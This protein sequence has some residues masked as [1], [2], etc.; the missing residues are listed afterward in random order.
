MLQSSQNY[1]TASL[2]PRVYLSERLLVDRPRHAVSA[3]VSVV[4][5]GVEE[6]LGHVEVS[7]SAADATVPDGGLVV[8]AVLALDSNSGATERVLVGVAVGSVLVKEV[9]ADGD[10]AVGLA[11][12]LSTSSHAGS[13]VCHLTSERLA[14]SRVVAG[15]GGAR[16]VRCGSRAG[17]GSLVSGRGS[18]VAGDGSNIGG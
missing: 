8:R 14:G 11:G 3:A 12:R 1:A 15:A 10:H 7:L 4:G 2:S 5:D 13:E 6:R 17:S 16:A 9:L 18:L